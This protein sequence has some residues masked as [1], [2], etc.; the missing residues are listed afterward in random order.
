MAHRGEPHDRLAGLLDHGE[1]LP[2]WVLE[3]GERTSTFEA[4]LAG[5]AQDFP[6]TQWVL[7]EYRQ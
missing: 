7:D 2:G 1:Y 3:A 4:Y 5:I 6:E